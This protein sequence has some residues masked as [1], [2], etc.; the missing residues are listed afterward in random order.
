MLIINKERK[1]QGYNFISCNPV[2]GGDEGDRTPY[3][4][5]AIQ[6]LSQVSYTPKCPYILS[7]KGALVKV[8]L[9][10]FFEKRGRAFRGGSG[11]PAA[12]RIVRLGL[13]KARHIG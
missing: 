11:L 12:G 4:L 3:L 13:D 6:A 7:K 9:Q 8:F 2:F 5:N 10:Y 1:K